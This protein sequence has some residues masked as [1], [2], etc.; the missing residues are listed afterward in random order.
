MPVDSHA[1]TSLAISALPETDIELLSEI[2]REIANSCLTCALTKDRQIAHL[3]VTK[4][5]VFAEVLEMWPFSSNAT[6]LP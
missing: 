2:G 1:G 3:R 5:F 4:D 6:G